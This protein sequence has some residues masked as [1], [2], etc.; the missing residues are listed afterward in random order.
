MPRFVPELGSVTAVPLG[1][2]IVLGLVGASDAVH[3]AQAWT[4]LPLCAAASVDWGA[5]WLGADG[6]GAG[7]H[8]ATLAGWHGVPIRLAHGLGE[9]APSC[10]DAGLALP[11][12]PTLQPSSTGAHS[13]HSST[14][15]SES[16][17]SFAGFT[18]SD[19]WPSMPFFPNPTQRVPLG[20]AEIAFPAL[21]GSWEA[22]GRYATSA[23]AA[24]A[25]SWSWVGGF[26]GNARVDVLP[27]AAGAHTLLPPL[28]IGAVSRLESVTRV[29]MDTL[30]SPRAASALLCAITV[31][32]IGLALSRAS[33]N[34]SGAQSEAA[35]PAR[36]GGRDYSTVSSPFA[37]GGAGSA[38]SGA[39]TPS[40]AP[41]RD[42]AGPAVAYTAALLHAVVCATL[43]NSPLAVG[44]DSAATSRAIA[45]TLATAQNIRS[46]AS[47]RSRVVA[48]ILGV[49]VPVASSILD[50]LARVALV[51]SPRLD[52]ATAYDAADVEDE[53]TG[54]LLADVLGGELSPAARARALVAIVSWAFGASWDALESTA[55]ADATSNAALRAFCH[56]IAL[57]AISNARSDALSPA[58][59]RSLVAAVMRAPLATSARIFSS[60]ALQSVFSRSPHLLP[61]SP[62]SPE[63]QPCTPESARTPNFALPSLLGRFSAALVRTRRAVSAD[64]WCSGPGANGRALV[65]TA[66]DDAVSDWVTSY[67][68]TIDGAREAELPVT[69]EVSGSANS[70]E[71]TPSTS[72]R[73]STPASGSHRHSGVIASECSARESC[74]AASGSASAAAG[75]ALPAGQ[76]PFIHRVAS[77]ARFAAP[78]ADVALPSAASSTPRRVDSGVW[79]EGPGPPRRVDSGVWGGDGA[80]A[81]ASVSSHPPDDL[82]RSPR[83]AAPRPSPR[84]QPEPRVAALL[85]IATADTPPDL[86]VALSLL[87][88]FAADVH[89]EWVNLNT[90]GDTPTRS[91]FFGKRS[92][93]RAARLHA[94]LSSPVSV[95]T[96]SASAVDESCSEDAGGDLRVD[97][98]ALDIAPR[99]PAFASVAATLARALTQMPAVPDAGDSTTPEYSAIVAA[100][101]ALARACPTLRDVIFS[102][103]V[104]GWPRTHSENQAA[105]IDFC[106]AALGPRDERERDAFSSAPLFAP[107]STALRAALV[108]RI[109]NSLA[110]GHVRIIRSTATLVASAGDPRGHA[111]GLSPA[112]LALAGDD[113]S[114]LWPIANALQS[115]GARH[116]SSVVSTSATAAAA[117]VTSAVEA[118]L[119]AGG[120]A[121]RAAHE[122]RVAA[123]RRRED[124]RKEVT[125]G[126]LPPAAAVAL[127]L[128]PAPTL[129]T[130]ASINDHVGLDTTAIG[131]APPPAP[132]SAGV[133]RAIAS[134][135]D[136]SPRSMTFDAPQ[137]IQAAMLASL[138]NSLR[139]AA[140]GL[141]AATSQT[142][143]GSSSSGT[144]ADSG[145]VIAA[146]KPAPR[147]PFS[148]SAALS[149]RLVRTSSGIADSS[150]ASSASVSRPSTPA[151]ESVNSTHLAIDAMPSAA[152]MASSFTSVPC[153]SGSLSSGGNGGGGDALRRSNSSGI[154]LNLCYFDDAHAGSSGGGNGSRSVSGGGL[155]STGGTL[156][157]LGSGPDAGPLSPRLVNLLS[158]ADPALS[159]VAL[160]A[161]A[162]APRSALHSSAS[163]DSF[164]GHSASHP[165]LHSGVEFPTPSATPTSRTP[166]RTP[167]RTAASSAAVDE[168]LIGVGLDIDEVAFS[169]RNVPASPATLARALA[170]VGALPPLHLGSGGGGGGV[171]P[172]RSFTFQQGIASAAPAGLDPN[173]PP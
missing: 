167:L 66:L 76:G 68:K 56:E 138:R 9:A 130:A 92:F 63:A 165:S 36:G 23:Q 124:A 133:E 67:L 17:S 83:S 166:M 89:R 65:I 155:G 114:S 125:L 70:A 16:T 46:S 24:A 107:L 11:P 164:D 3:V 45:A 74:A 72:F 44:P 163:N 110:T 137:H 128:M 99:L 131:E 86:C 51:Y 109:A 145:H 160:A 123:H 118:A 148:S 135:P 94:R 140:D 59:A 78:N 81:A 40:A 84:A 87:T 64:E 26:G 106:S 98:V 113:A 39:S 105:L 171:T 2:P 119:E 52:A 25:G 22:T 149:A 141:S 57:S 91:I 69:S 96:S 150:I 21:A 82:S 34:G 80:V 134:P 173:A 100:A 116:W 152:L 77:A 58:L 47:F 61:Q 170:L 38:F 49:E 30:C 14:P 90:A 104:S 156:F 136:A 108:C 154:A 35:T 13:P 75:S 4:S 27:R 172:T 31:S 139:I 5:A 143:L 7:S 18:A 19:T 127:S 103:I 102:R 151:R 111:R 157:S 146:E 117:P 50:D 41:A 126:T 1:A 129:L 71:Y 153:S 73:P 60:R 53:S 101:L 159:V 158:H 32:P 6:G 97:T 55:A 10:V 122:E 29:L 121:A 93:N 144:S 169:P 120:A 115:A 112:M 142:D 8:D 79:G 162:A 88:D 85:T 161:A 147:F 132:S 15:S 54:A 95:S 62:T 33:F 48:K 43:T 168:N 20:A 28:T 12:S 37:F 42:A